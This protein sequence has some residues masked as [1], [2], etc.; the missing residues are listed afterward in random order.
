M[1]DEELIIYGA[2]GGGS[3]RATCERWP[4]RRQWERCRRLRGSRTAEGP[5]QSQRGPGPG[6]PLKL[7]LWH[8][9]CFRNGGRGRVQRSQEY[10]E[11]LRKKVTARVCVCV[12]ASIAVAAANQCR[13][14][15]RVVRQ[16]RDKSLVGWGVDAEG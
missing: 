6:G 10:F 15:A 16:P 11:K 14:K 9:S 12:D 5:G 13:L 2:V 3:G 1:K 4:W 7:E 8:R